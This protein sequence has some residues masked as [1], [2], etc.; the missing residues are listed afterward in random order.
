VVAFAELSQQNA[1]YALASAYVDAYAQYAAALDSLGA[2]VGD[3]VTFVMNKHGKALMDNANANI[4]AFVAV[5][6]E[7]IGG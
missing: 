1:D 3:P 2:P 6:L 4:R 7:Q 5:R